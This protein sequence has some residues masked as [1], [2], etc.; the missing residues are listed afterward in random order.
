MSNKRVTGLNC[1]LVLTMFNYL[2]FFFVL[3]Q[4]KIIQLYNGNHRFHQY[5][6]DSVKTGN[7]I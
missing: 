5:N 2:I 4:Y 3:M 6:I 7:R 1:F